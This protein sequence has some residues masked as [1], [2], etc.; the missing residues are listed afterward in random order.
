[1]SRRPRPAAA[2]KFTAVRLSDYATGYLP[3]SGTLQQLQFNPPN[4]P[5]F[6]Q[7]TVPFMGDYL[8]LAP[9][10]AFVQ[11]TNGQW[12]FN[13]QPTGS[14]VAHAFWTDNRDVRPPVDGNWQNYT[15]V[16]SDSVQTRS[17]FDPNQIAPSC[18][19]G[20]TGMR[21]QNVYTARVTQG[22]F[23]GSPG[24]AKTLGAIQ[25]AF[26]VTVQNEGPAP[27][28]YRL[29]IA[30]QPPGGT[31]SFLQFVAGA[32]PLT[33]IDVSVPAFSSVARSVFATSSNPAATIRVD[34]AEIAAPGAGTLLAGG[35]TGAVVLNGDASNPSIQNPSIQN[36]SIQ[37]PDIQVAE[38][39]NPNITSAFVANPS[40]QNPSIQNVVLN[41]SIQNPSIQNPSIQNP[42]LQNDAI[43]NLSVVNPS[44][45]NPSIQNPSIQNPSL[46]NPSI[47]NAD[48]VSG[49]IEDTTWLVTNDGNTA[50]SY[51]IN[52]VMN[53]SVPAGFGR[54]LLIHKTYN[55]PAAEDCTLALQP[56]TILLANIPNPTFTTPQNAA[57]PSIQNPSIQNPT[58]SLAPG[59]SADVTLRITDPNRFDGVT[60]D[61]AAAVT[62]AIVAHSVNTEDAAQGITQPRFALP[63]T[64]TTAGL[65]SAT[66]GERTSRRCRRSRARVRARGR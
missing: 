48:V 43:A 23:V 38:V 49:A 41:P 36:P 16:M 17:I 10:P 13:T 46:Q 29:T 53:G 27:H 63:L 6:R 20:H 19:A 11:S 64:I 32:A 24:N 47:Q 62:P 59:E 12:S 44:I 37:N 15:P 58:I 42:S 65:A 56:H 39:Y 1:M 28:S 5:L 2:P 30:N 7:G 66:P 4:L 57:N 3:G 8:D 31:A 9:A 55:T 54:Q 40:I 33:L 61:A 52:L 45:Q 26:V 25:R 50:A 35:L 60:F 51:A 18:V 34:V 14:S 22:L 21:N